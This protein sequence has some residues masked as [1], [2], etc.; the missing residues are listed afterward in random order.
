VRISPESIRT[1][2]TI[3]VSGALVTYASAIAV[4]T[5]ILFG[6]LPALTASRATPNTT[7]ATAT[8]HAAGS[9]RQSRARHVLVVGEL[10]IALVFLTGAGL[11]ARTFWRATSVDPGFQ[12]KNVLAAS[13]ELGDRYT[14]ATAKTFF[15]EAD[16]S[17]PRRRAVSSRDRSSCWGGSC[18]VA[19]RAAA[20][21]LRA[22]S[23]CGEVRDGTDENFTI[24]PSR[25][26]GQY[27]TMRRGS[28]AIT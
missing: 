18:N 8:Q 17:R 19:L 16:R 20:T 14:S 1:A 22:G 21:A 26:S 5:A 10:A 23:D 27:E 28:S 15:D 11:V 6:L 9:R 24:C 3:G 12:P 13:F 25:Q 7:L 2:E 4:L